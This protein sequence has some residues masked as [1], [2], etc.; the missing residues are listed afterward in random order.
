MLKPKKKF[1]K[2][3]DKYVEKIY[4]FIYLKVDTQETAEDITSQV[5]TKTWKVVQETSRKNSNR[6]E[7]ENVSAYLYQIA[8]AEIANHYRGKSKIQTISVESLQISDSRVDL[9]QEQSNQ[10]EIEK[11]KKAIALLD[12]DYQ[13]VIIWRHLDG[14]P[15]KKIAQIMKKPEGTVRMI[16]HR[17]LKQLRGE[18]AEK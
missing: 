13:N 14:L 3:Y 18:I 10:A 6:E 1:S 12:D 4:R 9:E 11:M 5:F 16:N 15:Y 17:A 8:R 7:I 2:I